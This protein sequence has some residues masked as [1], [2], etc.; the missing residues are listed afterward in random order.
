MSE[1]SECSRSCG[2]GAQ[3]RRVLCLR[4]ISKDESEILKQ[5]NCLSERP[6]TN[7]NCNEHEC[8]AYWNVTDWSRVGLAK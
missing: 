6:P 2:K 4:Q 7:Q 3:L 1:W 5:D 8:P